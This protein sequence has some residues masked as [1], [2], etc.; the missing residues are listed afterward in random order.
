M[1]INKNNIIIPVI[2]RKPDEYLDIMY[3]RI[4]RYHSEVSISDKTLTITVPEVGY[5][6][7]LCRQ[8]KWISCHRP[9]FNYTVHSSCADILL[10]SIN[11]ETKDIDDCALFY[12][13]APNRVS[14]ITESEYITI[15]DTKKINLEFKY[16][17]CIED[18][19][20]KEIAA[21]WLNKFKTHA[22]KSPD[23]FGGELI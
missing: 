2:I 12:A 6:D 8:N 21:N 19:F 9:F 11:K 1:E 7:I 13:V 15:D 10:L 5:G 3:R 23:I 22:K 14:P 17:H 4:I 20:V 16:A 18:D